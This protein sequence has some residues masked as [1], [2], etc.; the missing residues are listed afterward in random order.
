MALPINQIIQ[1]DCLEV[2][3]TFPDKS[4]DLVLTDPPYGVSVDYD[5]FNDSA[6]NILDLIK[7]ALPEMLRIGKRVAIFSGVHN[8]HLYDK[9]DWIMAWTWNTTG[10]FGKYGFNQ[11]QPI[12]LY[13]DDIK[14]FGSV[15]GQIKSDRLDFS[16]M[17]SAGYTKNEH[18]CPKPERVM[19]KAIMRLSN[20]NDIVFDPF[21]GSGSTLV[22]AKKLGRNFI[23]IE[24]SPEYCKIAED[25]LRQE[26]LF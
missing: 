22:A 3:K 10:S 4:I 12:L 8:I 14:S 21:M 23:G 5:I 2:M 19:E 26:V 17:G 18:P 1:G 16:G 13:G 25:R 15:N 20:E 6:D 11:W 9:P 7:K 24:I